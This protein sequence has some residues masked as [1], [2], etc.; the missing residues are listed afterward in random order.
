[1]DMQAIIANATRAAFGRP[2]VN[3]VLRAILV[4]AIVDA[5]LD[6]G[7]EWCSS[8]WALCDFKHSDGTRLEVK[9]SAARQSWHSETDKPSSAMFD[10]APRKMAWDGK[11]WV[12]SSGRNAEIY[13]F[14]HHP[15]V[16]ATADHRNPAQWVFY[17]VLA[18]T[19]PSTARISL[20]GVQAR[21][22][23]IEVESLAAAV[24]L[25]RAGVSGQPSINQPAQRA[26]RLP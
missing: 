24:D 3:N 17:V 15:I 26:A 11:Q 8:D 23:A 12:P 7:W 2:L 22:L 14:A 6:Q 21:A 20:V 16:D 18:S 1:M 19:L 13:V 10:I 4:E 9:Q 25:A 5:S